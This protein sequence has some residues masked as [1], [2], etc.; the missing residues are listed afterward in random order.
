MKTTYEFMQICELLQELKKED[1][2][3][4]YP[5]VYE[6]GLQQLQERLEKLENTLKE[7]KDGEN[8]HL[9]ETN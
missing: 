6:L 8:E 4:K 3:S 1:L 5:H 9:S 7:L 2:K